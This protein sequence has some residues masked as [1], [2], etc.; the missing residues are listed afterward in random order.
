[1]YSQKHGKRQLSIGISFTN[2]FT[3]MFD[4]LLE[5]SHSLRGL[6]PIDL[7]IWKIVCAMAQGLDRQ[8]DAN[9]IWNA[10]EKRLMEM[11]NP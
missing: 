9:Q 3:Q 7:G 4:D 10:I 2:W 11:M 1:M 6:Q 8:K 5:P